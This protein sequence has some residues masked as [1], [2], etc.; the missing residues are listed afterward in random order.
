M[1]AHWTERALEPLR[2]ATFVEETYQEHDEAE[3]RNELKGEKVWRTGGV[4]VWALSA[5]PKSEETKQAI[6][7]QW[8]SAH[9]K[10]DW[11]EAARART[12]FYNERGS[13]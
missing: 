5:E 11:L 9:G 13:H 12:R 6:W 4:G 1:T 2:Y 7:R 8:S 3:L 10:E